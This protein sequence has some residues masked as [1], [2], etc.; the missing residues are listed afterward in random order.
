MND[1]AGIME[2][3]RESFRR[4]RGGIN[5]R[6]VNI[7]T[8]TRSLVEQQ[9][10]WNVPKDIVDK[11]TEEHD[12]LRQLVVSCNESSASS[13]DRMHRNTL[14][15]TLSG[16]C[17]SNVRIWAYGQ[18]KAGVMTA[19]DVHQLGLLLPGEQGGRRSRH[20]PTDALAYVKAKPING[21]FVR[22]VLDRAI[23]ENA[24]QVVS[25]WPRGVRHALIVILPADGS[26]EIVRRMTTRLHNNITLPP[27]SHG[28]LFLVKAAFLR[29]VDD[30]PLFGNQA[31]FSMPCDTSDL[32][33]EISRGKETE[34]LR[35]ENERLRAEVERLT[36]KIG[37]L[38]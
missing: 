5:D 26:A 12:R 32:A 21:D 19:D 13:V 2:S 16:Y 35:L 4:W 22:I 11:L 9:E 36:R 6:F 10:K 38:D 34:R 17:R 15:K 29:H 20:E 3:F 25:G 33:A 8:L 1:S 28:K 27:G 14:L 30:N 31:V 7:D 23:G 24:A 37:K 18:Y